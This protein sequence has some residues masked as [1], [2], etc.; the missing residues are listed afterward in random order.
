MMVQWLHQLCLET[1]L[2]KK[3]HGTLPGSKVCGP[4]K[5]NNDRLG[6]RQT[7]KGQITSIN[8]RSC[9]NL[10][11]FCACRRLS[12]PSAWVICSSESPSVCRQSIPASAD[13]PKKNAKLHLHK[14]LERRAPVLKKCL[15]WNSN[16][17]EP[18]KTAPKNGT[19]SILARSC[20]SPLKT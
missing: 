13:S 11:R 3:G 2:G 8:L 5:M 9:P 10:C 20:P 16:P 14:L 18:A 12:M 6:V 4:K 1:Q 7:T 15:Y 19:T 17:H